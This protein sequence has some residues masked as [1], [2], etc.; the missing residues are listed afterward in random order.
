VLSHPYSAGHHGDT[1]YLFDGEDRSLILPLVS[2]NDLNALHVL[3][4]T[5]AHFYLTMLY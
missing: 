4:G 3:P 2:Q 5:A 1:R